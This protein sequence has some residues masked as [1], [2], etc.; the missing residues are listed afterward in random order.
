MALLDS[1][2]MDGEELVSQGGMPTANRLREG[3]VVVIEC[4][5][6]IPCN[7]CEDACIQGAIRIGEPTTNKPILD[8]QACGGCGLCIASCPG[9]AIFV[10]N[11]TY[12]ED[13]ATVQF[14][15][16]FSPLPKVGDAVNG[17]DREGSMVCAGHIVQVQSPDSY[18]KTP[19][20]TVAVSS[21]FGMEVRNISLMEKIK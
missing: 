3:P 7:P 9:Q 14:P 17:L 15:Y 21:R 18:D 8:E 5:Q 19:V 6:E 1:G 2:V 11:M 12:T 4:A 10:V 13:L 16:E 20:V